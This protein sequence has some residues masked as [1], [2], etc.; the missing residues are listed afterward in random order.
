MKENHLNRNKS[1]RKS[2][3]FPA[4]EESNHEE[5]GNNVMYRSEGF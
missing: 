5:L 2:G 1:I 4:K 3:C